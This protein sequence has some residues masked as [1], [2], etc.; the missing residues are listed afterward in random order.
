[1]PNDTSQNSSPAIIT[2]TSIIKNYNYIYQFDIPPNVDKTKNILFYPPSVDLASTYSSYQYLNPFSI[3]Y[4]DHKTQPQSPLLLTIIVPPGELPDEFE[5][6]NLYYFD[7]SRWIKQPNEIEVDRDKGSISFSIF[8]FSM[9]RLVA[10]KKCAH[11]SEELFDIKFDIQWKDDLGDLHYDRG[12][13][14]YPAEGFKRLALKIDN[15]E[16]KYA[17]WNVVFHGTDFEK[18]KDITKEGLKHS[19]MLKGEEAK[20]FA[21]NTDS[22]YKGYEE[23]RK[24]IYTSP[25]WKVA[26]QYNKKF[27]ALQG[28]GDKFPCVIL[29]CRVNPATVNIIGETGRVKTAEGRFDKHFKN[30]ELE[31]RFKN[32]E[33]VKIYGILARDFTKDQAEAIQAG[34]KKKFFFRFF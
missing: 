19:G 29:Q 9:Y 4:I 16:E 2:T 18:L 34:D 23:H 24:F 11:L 10:E 21:E 14:Y 25:S 17:N 3:H 8:H 31:W 33:D 13:P 20:I 15:F 1:L 28:E 7:V 32:C 6:I 12:K 22:T 26:T 5:E 27:K 30:S